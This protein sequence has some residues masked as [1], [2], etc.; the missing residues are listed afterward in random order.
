[1]EAIHTLNR[2]THSDIHF[3]QCVQEVCNKAIVR[4]LKTAYCLNITFQKMS[5]LKVGEIWH[6]HKYKTKKSN[7]QNQFPTCAA[8]FETPVILGQ[9]NYSLIRKKNK[10]TPLHNTRPRAINLWTNE[11]QRA[12]MTNNAAGIA[13][14]SQSHDFAFSQKSWNYSLLSG[15][16]EPTFRQLRP[17]ADT[18]LFLSN[19]VFVQIP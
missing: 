18:L 19:S 11:T 17:W 2:H 1:M 9:W 12:M 7:F 5:G 6:L 10:A 15:V 8:Q 14:S 3:A 16:A 13:L 4:D